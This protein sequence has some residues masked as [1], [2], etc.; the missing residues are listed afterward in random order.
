MS[1]A[2]AARCGFAAVL[3]AIATPVLGAAARPGY[4]HA[5]QF[6]SE[7]GESGAPNGAWIS[8]AGF[9]PTGVFVLLFLAFA[10]P[11]FPRDRRTAIGL[12][13][14]AAVGVAYL[15]AAV[16]RCDA[17]CPT[18]GSL[19][20]SVHTLFGVLEYVGALVGLLLLAAAFRRSARWGSLL[21]ACIGAALLVAIGFAGMLDASLA[22]QRGVFQRVAEFGVFGWITWTSA[23]LLRARG[24]TN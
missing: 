13:C 10:A 20:Q 3:F 23:A 5:S 2:A 14:F 21:P 15:V 24:T 18:T 9:A 6:I 11:S 12:L 22:A 16:A 19:A 17:G 4:S 7:L 8:V 1:A